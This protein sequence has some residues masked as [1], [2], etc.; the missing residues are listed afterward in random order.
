VDPSGATE[1]SHKPYGERRQVAILFADLSDPALS[2]S[3]DAEQVHELVDGFTLWSTASSMAM[4]AG[5]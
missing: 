3:L 2:R 4:A 1:T 5:R